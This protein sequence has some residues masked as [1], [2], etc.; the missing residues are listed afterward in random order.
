[1]SKLRLIFYLCYALM[2]LGIAALYFL[3]VP[4]IELTPKQHLRKL[5]AW[6]GSSYK[7]TELN[8]VPWETGADD[9]RGVIFTFRD[10]GEQQQELIQCHNLKTGR[11][12]ATPL[13]AVWQEQLDPTAPIYTAHPKVWVKWHLSDFGFDT[14]DFTLATLKDGRTL[15]ALRYKT[16]SQLAGRSLLSAPFEVPDYDPP[17]PPDWYVVLA[18]IGGVAFFLLVPLGFLLLFPD[19]RLNQK[20]AAAKWFGIALV[21]PLVT[22]VPYLCTSA[23]SIPFVLAIIL[24]IQLT[25]AWILYLLAGIIQERNNKPSQGESREV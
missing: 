1:M 8:A 19:F 5:D 9:F 13:P 16:T 11:K 2:L 6:L 18:G 12:G 20:W 23:L 10:H 25:G 22:I 17:L 7:R 15:L 14:R 24:P 4:E 3:P 21:F